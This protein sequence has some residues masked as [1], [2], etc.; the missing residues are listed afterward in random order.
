MAVAISLALHEILAGLLPASR[1]PLAMREIVTQ[2]RPMR[3]AVR[4]MRPS[5]APTARPLPER[6]VPV[7]ALVRPRALE[8]R[9]GG[10]ARRAPAVRA[11]AFARAP[12]AKPVW[13]VAANGSAAGT[14]AASNAVAGSG[15][16]AGTATAGSGRGNAAASGN[17]P[18]GFV[19]F[20]DPHG[21]QYDAGTRGF[22]VDIRMSVH[23]ADGSS[24]SLLLD[25]P[26]YYS[27]EAANPWSDRNVADPNFPVRFQPP[28][29]AKL[30][31]EPPLVQYVVRHSTADGM[32]LLSDCPG[33]PAN[34]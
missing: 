25:Y 4:V 3:I 2:V 14:G 22:W 13:D 6:I 7:T 26:W 28:P 10:P 9:A 16:G 21:S 24:Q 30:A 32:T 11:V 20:S 23:F 18:C 15:A 33:A 1:T 34:S 12:E 8:G 31:D 19:T 5:P 17:P 29:T 27:S